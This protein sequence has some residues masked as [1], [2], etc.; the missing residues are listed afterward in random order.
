MKKKSIFISKLNIQKNIRFT[1]LI[2]KM[3]STL[4]GTIHKI[5][6]QNPGGLSLSS[7]R[8][9][10]SSLDSIRFPQES[11]NQKGWKN[12]M[13]STLSLSPLFVTSG[14]VWVLLPD[15]PSSDSDTDS[16]WGPGQE[17]MHIVQPPDY[18]NCLA[19]YMEL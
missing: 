5:L 7:I 2:L 14:K 13:R 4:I 6:K 12:S 9:K 3:P 10:L 1:T 16:Q 18:L 8:D 11:D 19:E 15:D 17:E